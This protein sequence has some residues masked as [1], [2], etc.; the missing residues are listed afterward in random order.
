[1]KK[2]C[3]I[4]IAILLILGSY[5]VVNALTDA[6]LQQK[7]IELNQ[8]IEEAGKNIENIEVELTENLEAINAL[9]EEIYLYEEQINTLSQNLSNIEKQIIESEALL[10]EIEAKYEYQKGLLEKRLLYAYKSGKTR[11]LDVLLSSTDIM[12]F[13][14]K[15]HF[16]SEM[17]R[18]DENLL[19]SIAIQKNKIEEINKQLV[20]TKENLKSYKDEQKKITISIENSKLIRNSYINKLNEEELKIKEELNIYQD[21]LNLIEL[22]ILLAAMEGTSSE[23]VGGTFAWPAP[24][25]YTITSSYGMRFHPVIKLYRNHSG[26]DIGAPLG[27]YVIAANDGIV[28]KATYSYSY[29]NMIMIDHGGGVTTLYAHGSELLAQVGDVVKRGDAIMK[30]GST[31]WSTGPHL[32]FEIR[33]NGATIDPYPYITS[34]NL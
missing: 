22:E 4:V 8:K 33:I 30:A 13:I 24:G 23:F 15:Y 3:T 25:Y 6:E 28:T 18:Y 34:N 17:V 2:V 21:E 10:K 7:R 9:D 29:G 14:S 27:S 26:I 11:Y 1:M 5:N 32:H 12:D 16:V 19:E 31:G 20:T